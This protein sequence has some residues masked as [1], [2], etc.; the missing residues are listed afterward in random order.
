[1]A[2]HLAPP[3]GVTSEILGRGAGKSRG[4]ARLAGESEDALKLQPEHLQTRVTII[5]RFRC[6][7]DHLPTYS[8]VGH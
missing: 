8:H 5:F 7:F 2:R 6:V 4:L 1:M 3:W